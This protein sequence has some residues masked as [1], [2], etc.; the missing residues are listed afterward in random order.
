MLPQ[1]MATWH[2]ECFK[3]RESEKWDVQDELSD[4]PLNQIVMPS[5][6]RCPPYIW[7][8][9]VSLSP[10]TKGHREESEWTGFAQ[11]P[12]ITALPSDSSPQCI[13]H[14]CLVFIKPHIKTLRINCFFRSSCPYEGRLT[15]HVKFTLNSCIYFSP[16]DLLFQFNFQTQ[17][18][19]KSS[20]SIRVEENFPPYIRVQDF[21]RTNN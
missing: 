11:D 8:K 17:P 6:K 1:N 14:D 12:Q 21:K 7:R 2:T 4:L 20:R 5:H 15:C 9:G 19:L 3:L 10:R 16:V 18:G 13:F